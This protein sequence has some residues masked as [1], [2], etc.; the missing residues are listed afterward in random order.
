[1]KTMKS[2]IIFN[3]IIF[4]NVLNVFAFTKEGRFSSL[5][6]MSNKKSNRFKLKNI[7]NFIVFGDSYTT[8]NVDYD[9]MIS[10][11]KDYTSAYGPNWVFYMEDATDMKI[12]NLAYGGAT[13]AYEIS[14]AYL[15]TVLSFTDQ[16]RKQFNPKMIEGPFNDWE[17]NTTLF[18][19]WMGINDIGNRKQ[20]TDLSNEDLEDIT[21]LVYFRLLE[22]L[23]E[24]GARNFL[25]LNV[26]SIERSPWFTTM[27]P[28]ESIKGK[29]KS[30][31]KLLIKY[32]RDFYEDHKDIN[33]FIY[34]THSEFI[35]IEDNHEIF[36]I[37]ELLEFC[38]DLNNPDDTCLPRGQYYWGNG[39][40]PTFVVHKAMTDDIIKFLKNL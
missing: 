21:M 2:I 9:S 1:M 4:I 14:P 20:N 7:E 6:F 19:I 30:F 24:Y 17:P 18:G 23:Y 36:G 13:V 39:L 29:V 22:E 28:N 26:P 34:D 11:G 25:L 10:P 33:L 38:N 5:K 3:L 27:Y 8:T 40:H 15:T 32:A 37:T 31:N 35:Y 16:V 12:Y